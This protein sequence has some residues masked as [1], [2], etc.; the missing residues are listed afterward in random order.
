MR[1]RDPPAG[2]G[3]SRAGYPLLPWLAEHRVAALIPDMRAHGESTGDTMT[4]ALARGDVIASS[5]S[6]AGRCADRRGFPGAVAAIF[7]CLSRHEGRGYLLE[8]PYS[9]LDWRWLRGSHSLLPARRGR[10]QFV[11]AVIS[12]D[13]G[14]TGAMRSPMPPEAARLFLTAATSAAE[15]ASSQRRWPRAKLTVC[16][17]GH[18]PLV[19]RDRAQY[20]RTHGTVGCDDGERIAASGSRALIDVA[21]SAAAPAPA[22]SRPCS[23]PS[24][25]VVCSRRTGI[26]HHW[27]RRCA[28]D[29]QR[30]QVPRERRPRTRSC[31]SR[32]RPS[33]RWRAAA[34]RFSR[35]AICALRRSALERQRGAAAHAVEQQAVLVVA[36]VGASNDETNA[37]CGARNTGESDCRETTERVDLCRAVHHRCAAATRSRV[38]AQRNGQALIAVGVAATHAITDGADDAARDFAA[39]HLARGAA[40]VRARE[41]AAV[42]VVFEHHLVVPRQRRVCDLHAHASRYRRRHDR[43]PVEMRCS[44][45]VGDLIRGENSWPRPGRSENRS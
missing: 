9:T 3:E 32:T 23:S 30:R 8:S 41:S 13:P 10:T 6:A 34:R 35:R 5:G 12:T 37:R 7:A 33:N 14:D 21:R 44:R 40:H 16:G 20:R 4:S 36:H 28:R 22:R 31:R 17:E 27:H 39:E 29:G 43:Q 19:T 18:R 45:R 15:G 11:A 26:P 38:V 1:R 2:S 24:D 25:G 42:H